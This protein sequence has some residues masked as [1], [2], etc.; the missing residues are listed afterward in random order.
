VVAGLAL[1]PDS[2]PRPA[3]FV[4][5]DFF[6]REDLGGGEYSF[7]FPTALHSNTVAK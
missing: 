7:T 3:W 2:I 1:A 4:V 5:D 6:V